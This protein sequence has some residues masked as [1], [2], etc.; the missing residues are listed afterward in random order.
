MTRKYVPPLCWKCKTPFPPCACGENSEYAPPVDEV[1]RPRLRVLVACEFSGTVRDAFLAAGHDAW[2][3]DLLPS[4]VAGPHLRGDVLTYM[5]A[6]KW[7]LMI[8]FPPCTH[9][10]VSGAHRFAE[11]RREQVDA[12]DFVLSLWTAPIARIAIENPIGI[13]S[14]ELRDPD[15]IIQ[16]YEF[17]DDASKATCL[18]LKHLDRLDPLPRSEQ[19]RPRQVFDR[20]RGA[21]V[22]RWS[23]QTDSG[24]NKLGPSDDRWQLRASTYPGI[25][26]AMARQWGRRDRLMRS[27]DFEVNA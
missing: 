7:D 11:K 8:A 6:S 16:P 24:Q 1:E 21:L 27:L 22:Y 23:N 10:A 20:S 2:S 13:L 18:W 26:R 4:A 25:A 12:I 9:L 14:T 3:C 15:Q 5:R 17:G 19:A